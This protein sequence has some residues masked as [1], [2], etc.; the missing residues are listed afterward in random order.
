M[1][2]KDPPYEKPVLEPLLIVGQG[3]VPACIDGS[4]VDGS[5]SPNGAFPSISCQQGSSQPV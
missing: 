2:K 5:C 1:K 4:A 3:I